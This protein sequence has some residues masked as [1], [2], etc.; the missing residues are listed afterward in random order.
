MHDLFTVGT[1]TREVYNTATI[2]IAAARNVHKQRKGDVQR[3][4]WARKR[5][6]EEVDDEY[7]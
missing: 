3:K 1:M 7:A 4:E 2:N 6:R 5:K